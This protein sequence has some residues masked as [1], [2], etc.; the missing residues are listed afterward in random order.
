[1]AVIDMIAPASV[2]RQRK[3]DEHVEVGPI[4][5]FFDLVYV[6]TII[7]LSHT[8]LEHLTWRGALETAVLFLAVWWA[9]NYSAWAMNWIDPDSIRVRL[10]VGVMMVAAFWMAVALPHAFEDDAALFV[11][12]Y[13]ALQLIRSGFM[14][15]AF[16]GQDRAME[17]NYQHLMSWSAF[18]SIFWVA[19]VFADGDLRFGLWI[20]AVAIDYAAPYFGFWLPGRGARDNATWTLRPEHLAERNRLV[21]IIAL[22]ETVLITGGLLSDVELTAG[23]I[24][25]SIVG[26]GLLFCLW[27]NYFNPHVEPAANGSVS[28]EAGR[29]AYAYAHAAMVGGAIVVAVAIEKITAHP[30]GH[31]DIKTVLVAFGG[32]AIYLAGNIWFLRSQAGRIPVDRIAAVGVL[33]MLAAVAIVLKD[34][35]APLAALAAAATVF[36]AL[37]VNSTRTGQVAAR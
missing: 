37:A 25:A 24:T 30:G 14:V 6:L 32:P 9:W 23:V 5:L 12:G 29:S 18:A 3:D 2:L 13:V 1:M 36:V 4:E 21:F 26:F 35:I 20:A 16:R 17:Q 7:Q 8:L 19:G 28:T 15:A 10:L 11:G 22:G 34:D 31:V 33:A 27:W